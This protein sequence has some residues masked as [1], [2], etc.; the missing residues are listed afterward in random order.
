MSQAIPEP[1]GPGRQQRW[2]AGTLQGATVWITGLSGSGKSSVARALA[3]Q[4][5]E[6]GRAVFV[7]DADNLRLGLN[8]DLGFSEPDRLENVRRAGETAKLLAEAGMTVLVPIIS[9]H[10][11][12][13][14]AVKALHLAAGLPFLE[15]HMATDLAVC[16]ARDAKGL[17]ARARAAEFTTMT[18]I[19][20]PYERPDAPDLRVEAETAVDE[21]AARIRSLLSS[22]H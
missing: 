12:A 14:D 8:R 11:V 10:R 16:E 2:A 22:A 9:P 21:A 19:G 18:G 15:I 3:D 7:L 17:Y 6:A 1:E 20:S 5:L 4:L 13:R